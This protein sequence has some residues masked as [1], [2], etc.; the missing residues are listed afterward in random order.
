V[1]VQQ[2]NDTIQRLEGQI[3]EQKAGN[4]AAVKEYETLMAQAAKLD[5]EL[6][7]Q[8]HQN[9][10]LQALNN[11]Q[12]IELRVKDDEITQIKQECARVNKVREGLRKYTPQ[13]ALDQSI[14]RQNVFGFIF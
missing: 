10:Q 5:S 13:S 4:E 1:A 14:N 9:T 6:Q 12:Q 11:Q 7:E 8:I 2:G 3:R